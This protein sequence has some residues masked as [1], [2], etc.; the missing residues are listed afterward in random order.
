MVPDS[1]LGLGTRFTRAVVSSMDT[2][3]FGVP[4]HCA[5]GVDPSK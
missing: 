5:P 4:V 3:A 2:D 1:K